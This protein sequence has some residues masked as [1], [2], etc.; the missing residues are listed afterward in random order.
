[1]STFHSRRLENPNRLIPS[2]DAFIESLIQGQDKLIQMGSLKASKNQD[3]LVRENNTAQDKGRK[4]GKEKKNTE[5]KPKEKQNPSDGAFV[6][7]KDKHKSFEKTKCLYCK[8][9]NHP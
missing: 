5:T 9:G 1:M 2:L 7:K 3:L 4:K 8:R 6:Y